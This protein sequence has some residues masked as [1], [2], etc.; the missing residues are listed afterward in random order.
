MSNPSDFTVE[1][2]ND[3]D[4]VISKPEA[5][6]EV[7]YRREMYSR[8]L[9]A[10]DVLRSDFDETKVALMAQAWKLPSSKAKSLGWLDEPRLRTA[11]RRLAVLTDHQ[12]RSLKRLR[13]SGMDWTPATLPRVSQETWS[14]LVTLGYVDERRN[15]EAANQR[16]LRLTE[17]GRRVAD[18][19]RY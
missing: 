7:T 4:I 15:G 17:K 11:H 19:S 18:G 13:A 12:T 6:F 1:V 14:T 9:I 2:R 3:R 5:D 8:I 16:L 10:S